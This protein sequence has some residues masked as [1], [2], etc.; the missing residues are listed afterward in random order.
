MRGFRKRGLRNCLS[1]QCMAASVMI[2]LAANTAIIIIQLEFYIMQ[3]P[4]IG[5]ETPPEILQKMDPYHIGLTWL[6]RLNVRISLQICLLLDAD[7]LQLCLSDIIVVW[8]A[9]AIWPGN[10]PIRWVLLVSMG[11]TLGKTTDVLFLFDN[12]LV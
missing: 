8:R 6:V 5:L 11:A 4:A 1:R 9:L 7:Y 12:V 3:L 2:M 10:Q